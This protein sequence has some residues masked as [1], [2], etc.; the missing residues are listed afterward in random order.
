MS[1]SGWIG[2]DLDATLAE[3][4]GFKGPTVIGKPIPAMVARVKEWLRKG[5]EVRIFTARVYE[6]TSPAQYAT[7]IEAR[8]AIVAW[9][10][11]HIGQ[12]LLV[13]CQKDYEMW[14]LYDDR[15]RQVEPNTGRLL[16]GTDVRT[17][18]THSNSYTQGSLGEFCADCNKPL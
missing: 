13:T 6:G 18:C 17:Q 10:K 2:V 7:A 15:C 11:E 14:V 1:S 16:G 4:N 9:T 8:A 5:Y 3:Y 12:E